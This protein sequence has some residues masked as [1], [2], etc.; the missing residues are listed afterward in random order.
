MKLKF[1]ILLTLLAAS[2]SC[3]DRTEPILYSGPQFVFFESS[4]ELALL[5]DETD[6]LEIPIKI[7][8]AQQNDVK[9][10]FEIITKNAV[11]GSDFQILTPSPLSITAGQYATS[12][13]IKAID[14]N[15]I[16]AESRFVTIR[17][18]AIDPAQIQ[19]QILSEIVIEILND[20]C[21]FVLAD[22]VG[23]FDMEFDSEIGNLW[24]TGVYC[25]EST[26]LRLGSTPGTLVDSNFFGLAGAFATVNDAVIIRFN[27][28][29]S[30][31]TLDPSPQFAY[32]NSAGALRN[33]EQ[34][35]DPGSVLSTCKPTFTVN[36]LVRR[37][38]G[39]VVDFA[40]IKYTK[41]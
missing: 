38:V 8:L 29:G 4:A 41:K 11:S 22:F 37:S 28:A 1:I 15:V 5:E 36:M 13:K 27:T 26:T 23:D 39:T 32:T 17:V 3:K 10:G 2:F 30:Q 33:Y 20:D 6:T 9:I 40:T 21:P 25:C 12:F 16:E 7:S 19:S 18:K 35:T 31:I 34:D 24:D 14:N